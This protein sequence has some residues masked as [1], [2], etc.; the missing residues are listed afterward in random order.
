LPELYQQLRQPMSRVL[1]RYRIPEEHG[2]DLIQTTLLL[3]IT[4]WAEVRDPV[5]WV[6]GTLTNRCVLYWRARQLEVARFEPLDDVQSAVTEPAQETHAL[7][8]DLD[9]ASR[10]L[11]AAQRRLLVLRFQLGLDWCEVAKEMGMAH[12]STKKRTLRAL[13]R[14]RLLLG[15][16]VA[17][18]DRGAARRG[19]QQTGSPGSDAWTTAIDAYLAAADLRTSTARAS[20]RSHLIA[21]GAVLGQKTLDQLEESD[22]VRYRAALLKD[23]RT[24]GTHVAAF[25]VL[26]GFLLWT[27]RQGWHCVAASGIRFVLRGWRPGSIRRLTTGRRRG[28]KPGGTE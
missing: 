19:N 4:K 11:P 16:P 14:L 26:R 27:G 20:Y 2:E 7:L 10:H 25:M 21:A 22:L 18:E 28:S 5:A 12:E 9:T 17:H 13:A 23:G 6:L 3:A 8:A 1:Y 24:E 15:A